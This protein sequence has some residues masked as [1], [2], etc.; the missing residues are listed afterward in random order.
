MSL[1]PFIQLLCTLLA[2]PTS[3]ILETKDSSTFN[4]TMPCEGYDNEAYL[5]SSSIVYAL[6]TASNTIGL[7]NLHW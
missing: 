4:P 5:S 3:L 7:F 1:P 6:P 2:G